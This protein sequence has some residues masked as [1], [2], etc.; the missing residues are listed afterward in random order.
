LHIFQQKLSYRNPSATG[1]ALLLAALML[2]ADTASAATT[3]STGGVVSQCES[4]G[5]LTVTL[6]GD[7]EAGIDW[8]ATDLECD[9]M[10][11]PENE[12]ARLRFSGT[13]TIR[14]KTRE[15][16]FIIALPKLKRGQTVRETPANVTVIEE[17]GGRFFNSSQ[18][19]ACLADIVEQKP[20][21]GGTED[22]FLVSGVLYC[23]AAIVE[24]NGSG[25]LTLSDLSFSGHLDWKIPE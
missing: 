25:G 13:T 11:R 10:P 14:G 2:L 1:Y 20:I 24:L 23:V 8:S 9:G 21:K 4:S 18:A 7:I 3:P 5:R 12:G 6:Y 22:E 16:A 17:G 15:I 19:S